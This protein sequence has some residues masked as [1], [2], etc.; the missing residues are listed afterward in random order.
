MKMKRETYAELKAAILP[1]FEA[2][3][4]ASGE[5]NERRRWDCFFRCG[6]PINRLCNDEGLTDDHIDTALR[7]IVREASR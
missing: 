2:A 4:I 6:F 1:F 5:L 7:A 3:A